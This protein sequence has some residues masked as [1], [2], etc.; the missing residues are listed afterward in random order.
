MCVRVCVLHVCMYLCINIDDI[1]KRIC[2]VY[3]RCAYICRHTHIHTHTH[4]HTHTCIWHLDAWYTCICTHKSVCHYAHK[5][6]ALE[7]RVHNIYKFARMREHTERLATAG[8]ADARS[9]RPVCIC[10]WLYVCMYAR[11]WVCMY[12]YVCTNMS[13]SDKNNSSFVKL[14]RH[15]RDAR[16]NVLEGGHAFSCFARMVRYLSAQ[17]RAMAA[18]VTWWS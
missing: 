13:E 3:V 9:W 2:Y 6:R 18:C 15:C 5:L 4:A 12:V 7:F 16:T 10:V 11:M 17:G 14:A 1:Y 8:A